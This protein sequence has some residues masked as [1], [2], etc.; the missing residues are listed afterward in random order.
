MPKA[1]EIWVLTDGRVGNEAQALALAEAVARQRGGKITVKRTPLRGWAGRIPAA[2]SYRLGAWPRG[3]PFIGIE[4]GASELNWPWPALIVSAGR[5]V[6]PISAALK[7]LYGIPAVHLLDPEIPLTA[8]DAVVLP[9]HDRKSASNAISSL[10]ALT[11]HTRQTLDAA[12]ASWNCPM[13]DL[14]LPRLAVLIGGPSRSAD[15]TDEDSQRLALALDSLAGHFGLMI[16]ASRR[17][18]ENLVSRLRS[19]LAVRAFI[20]A[21]EADGPNPYPGLL[22]PAV[23]VIVTEDSVNMVSEAASTGKPVHVFPIT[24]VAPKLGQFH[25]DLREYGATQRFTGEIRHW[26]YTPLAEADRVAKELVRRGIV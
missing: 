17:T 8:F 20:W 3:W 1:T 18:P 4:R 25:A 11:R 6:A 24:R 14:K 9:R 7:K 15:F 13:T 19:A 12:A 10:G 5:R 21:S 2:I 16:T 26:S 23:A 22:G